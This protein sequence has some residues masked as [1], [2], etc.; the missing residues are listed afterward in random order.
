L[1]PL[2]A[3][4]IGAGWWA[5]E[6]YLPVLKAHRQ[7]EIV[8]ISRLGNT[9]LEQVRQ[10]FDVP[11]AFTDYRQMLADCDLDA[12][13]VASPHTLHFEHAMAALDRGAH[14]FV[15]KPMT[16]SAADARVLA[17]R[18][19][20]AG[21]HLV[22]SLGWNFSPMAVEAQARISA[23]A[24]GEV[25]H[26]TLHMASALAD[27]FSGAGLLEAKDAFF[28]PQASTWAD[29]TRAGGYGWGQLSHALG[30]LFRLTGLEPREVFAFCGQSS[31][32][33][34]IYDA[35]V[36]RFASGATGTVSGAA[37]APKHRGFQMDLRVFGTEGM[38][39][40]DIER[41]RVEVR[42]HD[43]ADYVLPVK[44][45]DGGYPMDR[46]LNTFID[47][48]LGVEA[49]NQAP[50]EVGARSV[51]VLEALYNSARSGRPERIA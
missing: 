30:L 41:E 49:A 16:T 38:L 22:V 21:R 27:L 37:T 13:I 1:K 2:R 39:L 43:G 15:E 36:I 10:K 19:R 35:A 40:F 51:E 47:L 8:A 33:V 20:Q 26:V 3:G 48:C 6:A 23:G 28:K 44:P 12:V 11:S 14:V 50:G 46:A 7:V 45:G 42:R 5:T 4:V 29:P 9:E 18:A 17:E 24:I 32:N 34:D 25:R 31:A